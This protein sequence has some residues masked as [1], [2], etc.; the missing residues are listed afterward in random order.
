MSLFGNS[1][2]STTTTSTTSNPWGPTIAPL[3]DFINKLGPA[4]TGIG[5]VTPGQLDAF[6][7]LQTNAG[8]AGQFAPAIGAVA[9]DTFNAGSNSG[10]VGDAYKTLQSQLGGYANGDNLDIGNNPYIQGLLNTARND[11]TNTINSQWGGAGRDF[12][13]GHAMAM[14]RGIDSAEA[15]ILLNQYNTERGA[16]SDAAKTLY[17]GGVG[18]AQ[19]GQ[20]MDESALS[21]RA[22]GVQLAQAFQDAKNAGPNAILNLQEQL[23][24]LPLSEMGWLAQYLFPAAQLGGTSTG[25]SSTKSTGS[26]GGISIGDIGKL[27]TALG[28]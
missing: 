19:T 26:G 18:A 22:G 7:Q 28:A 24:G 6:G 23:K 27:G 15:P 3:Q 14:S 17:T 5:Q 1:K 25:T 8:Q 4:S 21:T 16:Q 10:Q 9:S 2:K 12:S 13:A 20:S 11:A